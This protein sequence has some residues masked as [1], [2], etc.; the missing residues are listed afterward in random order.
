MIF[1]FLVL[2]VLLIFAILRE[3]ERP[4]E[5]PGAAAADCPGCGK[6][7][8]AGWLLCPNCRTL[9]QEGCGC[10]RPRAVY[11]PFCP[12]CGERRKEGGR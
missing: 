2:L 6:I 5:R 7:V 1:F 12:W 3:L 8:E 10:G 11:H 4:Q 9:L